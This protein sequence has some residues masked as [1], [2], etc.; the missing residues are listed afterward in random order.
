MVHWFN[1]PDMTHFLGYDKDGPNSQRAL[2]YLIDNAG[3]RN[4]GQLS[5]DYGVFLLQVNALA[6]GGK[7]VSYGY[8]NGKALT[9]YVLYRFEI[10]TP[11]E[12]W[13]EIVPST[14][15]LEYN[16]HGWQSLPS[17]LYRYAVK[18]KYG[19]GTPSNA[20]ISNIVE[21]DMFVSFK[22]LVTTDN[23]SSAEGASIKLTN[24][25]GNPAHIFT[26]SA[27]DNGTFTFNIYKGTY[28]ITVKLEKYET[29][30]DTDVEI[31]ENGEREIVLNEILYPVGK[32]TAEIV[33][34]DVVVSWLTPGTMTE[35]TFILDSGTADS[36]WGI[37][38]SPNGN[39]G[40]GNM[41]VA[42]EGGWITSV[43][44]YGLDNPSNTDR[45]VYIRIYNE[46]QQLISE[47]EGFILPSND[48]INVPV[49]NIEYSGTFYAFVYWPN[50]TGATHWLGYSR[51]GLE[52][53]AF[54]DNT[55]TIHVPFHVMPSPAEQ[56]GSFM[57]RVNAK[58]LD[59]SASKAPTGYTVYRLAEGQPEESWTLL[60]NSVSELT[61]TD[62]AWSSLSAGKY[63]WAVKVNY[64]AGTSE[65]GLTNVLEKEVGIITNILS[66]IILYPN[67][68][69]NEIN[70][71]KP[72]MVKNI[73]ITDILG[74]TIKNVTFNGKS[75]TT[76]ALSSGIY[77]V[78][79]ESFNGESIVYKMIKN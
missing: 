64:T 74:Q 48:W 68:F 49:D 29:Y 1:D 42:E 25:D 5:N 53:N 8:D 17:G 69:Q 6:E 52:V 37:N 78:T 3:W 15:E 36:G 35:K 65:A 7:S 50:T 4:F 73:R 47:S 18:A 46:T 67:P 72:E 51:N 58:V 75:I 2:S 21:K 19:E 12:E 20:K 60:S 23:G 26:G 9:D 16:D 63:Q 32:P 59:R 40:L 56:P 22:V 33:D 13:T 57:V 77:F 70:I 62:D 79:L 55:G 27:D 43:D 10:D 11:E 66:D 38:P 14:T 54:L 24:Q 31:T 28:N 71:N 76:E 41:F 39:A 34:N 30:Y 44:V 45:T 61:Y